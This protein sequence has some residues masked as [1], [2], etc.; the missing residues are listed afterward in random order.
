MNPLRRLP[1][2]P[3]PPGIASAGEFVDLHGDRFIWIAGAAVILGRMFLGLAAVP[4]MSRRTPVVTDAPWMAQARRSPR[5]RTLARPL[6]PDPC[7]DH[8]D[9][10]GIF[11]ART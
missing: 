3:R 8:A 11:R 7:V 9:G 10:V 1:T 4:W 5:P 6:P 2:A